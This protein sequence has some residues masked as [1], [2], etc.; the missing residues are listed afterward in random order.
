MNKSEI[1]QK[2][3]KIRK[4]N[5]LKKKIKINFNSILKVFKKRGIKGKNLGGY[6]PYNY[7]LDV[8]QILENFEKKNYFISLPKI[9]AYFLPESRLKFSKGVD[10][11]ACSIE[12]I[13]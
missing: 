6:Y 1:R 9:T 7:E 8:I 13:L 11:S 3:I 5:N 10:L 12:T 2:L 4:V